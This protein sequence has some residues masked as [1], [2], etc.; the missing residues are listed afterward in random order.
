MSPSST[1]RLIVRA[2]L[3]V[4]QLLP[5]SGSPAIVCATS[6]HVRLG[7]ISRNGCGAR[8]GQELGKVSRLRFLVV[9]W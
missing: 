1:E 3:R 4:R 5:M 9:G 2:A 7:T 8:A 6:A